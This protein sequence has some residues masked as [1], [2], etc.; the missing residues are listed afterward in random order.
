MLS[1]LGG[2]CTTFNPF[3]CAL[4]HQLGFT[5]VLLP[6]SMQGE[7]DMHMA[8]G[9]FVGER[10]YWLDC[11]NGFPY[12]QPLDTALPGSWNFAGFSY[13][14]RRNDHILEI[15]QSVL[16]TQLKR[17]NQRVSLIPVH[18]SHFDL[19]RQRH[20]VDAS[21][22]PFL[23]GLRLNRWLP[24]VGFVLRDDLIAD[25]PQRFSRMQRL[26]TEAWIREHFADLRIL[27][28]YREAD[29]F[30]REER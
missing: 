14:G 10:F 25:A 4:L 13:T 24:N 23:T 17:L 16:G 28:L 29:D 20:Y 12:L 26:E 30:L 27:K 6:S 8:V 7:A 2:L 18:Y 11:G 22:G 1:G 21:Y 3:L 5:P 15:E 9:V 19:M